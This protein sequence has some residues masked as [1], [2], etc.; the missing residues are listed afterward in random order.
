MLELIEFEILEED[1]VTTASPDGIDA[2]EKTEQDPDLGRYSIEGLSLSF[3]KG[4][5]RIRFCIPRNFPNIEVLPQGIVVPIPDL[6]EHKNSREK[7][8]YFCYTDTG[9]IEWAT[10]ERDSASEPWQKPE[11]TKLI[12]QP[13]AIPDI[14]Q[15]CMEQVNWSAMQRTKFQFTG[16]ADD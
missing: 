12:F 16:E 8:A 9:A 3:V 6:G 15:E 2:M 5:L 13:E 4:Y 1:T 10:W 11:F 7:A 14:L